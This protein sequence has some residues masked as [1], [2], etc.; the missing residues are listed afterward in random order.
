LSDRLKRTRDQTNP[1]TE[2]GSGDRCLGSG[3]TTADDDDVKLRFKSSTQS[4][5]LR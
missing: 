4:H 1:G 2:S 3:M 5:T